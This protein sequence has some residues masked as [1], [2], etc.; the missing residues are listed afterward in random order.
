MTT[1][2]RAFQKGQSGNPA[3]RPKGSRS[4]TAWKLEAILQGRGRG[5]RPHSDGDGQRRRHR[6]DAPVP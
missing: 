6:R 2:G 3:G 5:R 4:K 1:R